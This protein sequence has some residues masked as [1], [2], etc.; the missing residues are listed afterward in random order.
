MTKEDIARVAKR[1]LSP[2][3][4]VT[5]LVGQPS[6]DTLGTLGNVKVIETLPNV[7]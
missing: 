7:E 6:Q 2:D 3:Q 5:V 4:F 1:L